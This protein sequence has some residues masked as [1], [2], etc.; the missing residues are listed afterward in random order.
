MTW[1]PWIV[2]GQPPS[3]SQTTFTSE[4]KCVVARD[5]VLNSGLE[6]RQQMLQEWK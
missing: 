6:I 1:V 4:Q 2:P 5:Q 3:N